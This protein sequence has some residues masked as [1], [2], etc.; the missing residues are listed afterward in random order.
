MIGESNPRILL[1]SVFYNCLSDSLV[2]LRGKN[3]IIVNMIKSRAFSF[4][5]VLMVYVFA[6]AG[7]LACFD[8]LEGKG[9]LSFEV[10]LLVAD[11]AATVIV[12]TFS[13]I[14]RNASVYDPYWSVQP[15]VILSVALIRCG[16]TGFCWILFAAV[17]LWGLR[18]TANWAY[19]FTG[20]DYQDWRYTMLKEKTGPAYPLINFLGLHFAPYSCRK[21]HP[22]HPCC[23]DCWRHLAWPVLVRRP[24]VPQPCSGCERQRYAVPL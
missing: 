8:F 7:G 24:Y 22:W 14:F 16:G 19:N 17:L 3:N 13:L 15:P 9:G 4:V 11:V 6:V 5:L 20:F 12:F 2:V 1:W 10:L 18:L 21:S 23:L